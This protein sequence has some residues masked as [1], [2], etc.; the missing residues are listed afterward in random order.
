[1]NFPPQSTSFILFR[2]ASFILH[3]MCI[4][5]VH[6]LQLCELQGYCDITL[7]VL[8]LSRSWTYMSSATYFFQEKLFVKFSNIKM[9]CNIIHICFCAVSHYMNTHECELLFSV[10]R[11]RDCSS[12]FFFFISS[13][14]MNTSIH[15]SC[16][17]LIL[18]SIHT[19][20]RIT[21]T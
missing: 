4:I 7:Y 18:S 12:H 15:V 8:K 13:N 21:G 2:K 9:L 19:R 16:V 5:L 3:F 14:A 20:N 17:L 10:N 6:F 11:Y 1:M